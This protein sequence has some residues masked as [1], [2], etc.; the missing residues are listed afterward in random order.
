MSEDIDWNDL[1]QKAAAGK[2]AKVQAQHVV[3][4]LQELRTAEKDRDLARNEIN[5][6]REDFNL[7]SVQLEK[8]ADDLRKAQKAPPPSA[9]L[10]ELKNK[11]ATLEAG[12]KGKAQFI[13]QLEKEAMEAKNKL[14]ELQKAA[15]SADADARVK[16]LEAKLSAKEKELQEMAAKVEAVDAIKADFEKIKAASGAVPGKEEFEKEKAEFEDEK[17]K[18]FAEMESFEVGLRMEME[19]KDAKIKELEAQIA[20]LKEHPAVTPSAVM[21]ATTAPAPRTK[22][23]LITK[24]GL[25]GVTISKTPVP[26]G[27]DYAFP[28]VGA[29]ADVV[30]QAPT[31]TR[32]VCPKC[33]NT[34]IKPE[35]DRSRVLSYMGGVPLYAKK[36]VCKKCMFEFRVD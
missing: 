24:L 16:E 33:G 12:T 31:E 25:E 11:V 19:Q 26:A 4:L 23:S 36:Y 6:M 17:K 3:D 27:K 15:G 30:I 35:N 8:L 10:G 21:A 5:K 28:G 18:L 7:Q 20:D 1:N 14:A 32:I 13:A 9:E 29:K 22:E 34:N 2:E